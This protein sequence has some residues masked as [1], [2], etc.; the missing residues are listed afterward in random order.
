MSQIIGAQLYT[1]REHTKTAEDFEK[2]LCRL[3]DMGFDTVQLSAQGKDITPQEIRRIAEGTGMTICCSHMPWQRIKNDL[4]AV[5]KEN[6]LYGCPI[7]GLSWW[8]ESSL[9]TMDEI[10]DFIRQIRDVSHRLREYG[11]KFAYH[12]HKMEF[13]RHEGK[14]VLQWLAENTDPDETDIIFCCCWA[15]AGG[16]DPVDLLYRLAG[17][18][19]CCHYKDLVMLGDRQEVCEVGQGNMNYPAIYRACEDTGV[20]Y[21][22]IEQDVCRR[23]PFECIE[24]S[25]NYIRELER[26]YL[27]R[28]AGK[29]NSLR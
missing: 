7:V 16:A 18:I 23:S 25:R 27:N 12:N 21:A 9:C 17:R 11:L 3:R 10:K 13:Q 24:I 5:A 15:M 29:D 20:R 14:T 26:N 8:P 1:L 22:L 6:L 2:T 4:D 19:T 28:E